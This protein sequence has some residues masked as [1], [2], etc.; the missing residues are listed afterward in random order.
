M[1][2]EIPAKNQVKSIN[3][4]GVGLLDSL[5]GSFFGELAT[6][7]SESLA[8]NG[9]PKK[10]ASAI[11]KKYHILQFMMTISTPIRMI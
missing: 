11:D 6:I 7:E 3:D 1:L 2:R 4:E 5:Y 9:K 8:P 10:S